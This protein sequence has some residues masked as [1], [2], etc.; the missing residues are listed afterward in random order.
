MAKVNEKL[1][2]KS[3]ALIWVLG[4]AGQLC[5]N[6]EN[7]WFNTFVYAKIGPY[8]SI[9]AWMT[10][11]SAAAT[12]ISTFVS[13]TLSDRIGRRKPFIFIGYI[14]WGLFTILFGTSEFLPKNSITAAAVMV[15]MMDALMSFF[16]SMGNDSG[17]NSWTTDITNEH[18]RGQLGAVM[19]AQPV[20]ATIVGTVGAGIIIE[21]FGYFEFFVFAGL[22]VMLIGAIGTAMLREGA[23]LRPVKDE[24]GFWHQFFSVF[25]FKNF[26]QNKQLF[27][28]FCIMS[29]YFICFNFY[30]VHVGNY[31]IYSLGYSEGAAGI[32]QG[33]GLLIAVLATIP[34][35][36]FINA[37]KHP[38]MIYTSVACTIIGLL[39]LGVCGGNIPLIEMGII[40]AGIGYVLVLQTTTAWAKNLYPKDNRG[41]YEGVRIIF[42]VLIP[43]VIGP[44][45]ASVIINNFGKAVVI[46]GESGMAPSGILF[47]FAA[48][49]TIF[50]VI[51]T[52]LAAKSR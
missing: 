44:A 28:V 49:F 42:F 19:A 46:N 10:A 6:I 45:I 27:F 8:A 7:Q 30:F 39:V 50:T 47:L 48:A 31:F 25:N 22:F 11:C 4:L 2:A 13:G 26:M 37:G 9:I 14:L 40:L 34:A 29:V 43:M 36:K 21:V 32:I 17:F 24:K 41:Q 12:T 51:P 18:N 1:S 23:E 16:G 5:W 20:I 38:Q 3:W 35:S 52:H 33:V 15:V